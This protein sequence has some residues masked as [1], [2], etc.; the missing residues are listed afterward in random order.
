MTLASVHLDYY[1]NA[2]VLDLKANAP[3]LKDVGTHGRVLG[4]VQLQQESI[5]APACR[6][7][8]LGAR[9][10]SKQGG[11]SAGGDMMM[12]ADTGQFRG[13]LQMMAFLIERDVGNDTARDR[14]IILADTFM[15]FFEY[16]TFGLQMCGPAFIT[17]FEIMYAADVDAQGIAVAAVSFEQEML[18][19]RNLDDED[20]ALLTGDEFGDYPSGQAFYPEKEWADKGRIDLA[21][22]PTVQTKITGVFDHTVQVAEDI[23][24]EDV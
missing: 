14:V 23:I 4:L 8:M 18:F 21:V 12:R 11:R 22:P 1:M 10:G 16:R 6:I 9:G 5:N 2:I 24:D 3:F 19:G 20:P 13:P 17:G 15:T 7:A